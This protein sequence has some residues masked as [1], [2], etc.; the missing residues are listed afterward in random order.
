MMIGKSMNKKLIEFYEKT[1]NK[2]N[3]LEKE[4]LKLNSK[5][6]AMYQQQ[7]FLS[8]DYNHLLHQQSNITGR[9]ISESYTHR[10]D[11]RI[12]EPYTGREG[13]KFNRL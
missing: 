10:T 13:A 5:I 7:R 4:I 3:K 8:G 6:D 2:I 12:S 9:E 11:A 1:I